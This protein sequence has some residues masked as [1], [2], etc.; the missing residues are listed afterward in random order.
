[1]TQSAAAVVSTEVVVEAPIE[2]A[3]NVFTER[4]GDFK[5]P[6]HNLLESPIAVTV[7]EPRV[8]GHIFDRDTDGSECALGSCPRLRATGPRGVQL[9]HQSS[10]ASRDRAGQHQRGGGSLRRGN[11]SAHP[12]GARAPQDRPP[13]N[14]LAGRRRGCQGRRWMAALPRAVCRLVRRGQLNA[15]HRHHPR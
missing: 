1:M 8:G 7:F 9:G 3:F 4:F 14:W 6:E 10:V 13:R 5:P 15:D 12:S 11:S 2:R